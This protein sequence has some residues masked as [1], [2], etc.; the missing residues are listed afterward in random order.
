MVRFS[1]EVGDNFSCFGGVRLF[2]E[3]CSSETSCSVLRFEFG[4]DVAFCTVSTDRLLV[5]RKGTKELAGDQL[6]GF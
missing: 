6:R 1:V 2:D 3:V 5:A 4:S